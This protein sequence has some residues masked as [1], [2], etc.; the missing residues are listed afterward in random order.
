MYYN[1]KNNQDF[2]VNLCADREKYTIETDQNAF[3]FVPYTVKHN[4]T[5]LQSNIRILVKYEP[6]IT[7]NS[8]NHVTQSV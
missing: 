5:Q 6:Q 1:S 2:E 4:S 8:E 7:I 3:G